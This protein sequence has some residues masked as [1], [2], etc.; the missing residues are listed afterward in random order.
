VAFLCLG[1]VAGGYFGGRPLLQQVEFA[2]AAA[3]VQATREQ[4]STVNDLSTVFRHVGKVVAPS[5]VQIRV[6]KELPQ[7]VG[8]GRRH[9]RIPGFGDLPIPQNDAPGQLNPGDNGPDQQQQPQEEVGTG[10]GVILEA[11]DGY[12]YILTNNHVAGGA[13]ELEVTLDDGR[14]IHSSD[15]KV[16]GADPKSDLAVVKIKADRLIAAKWGNSD[17]LEKGDWVMAF[18]S[19]FGYIG[20]MTHGIVS[21]LNRNGIIPNRNDYENYIQVDAPINPGNSGGPLVNIHG[22]VVGINV[23]IATVDGGFEGIGFAIPANQAKFVFSALKTNGKVTRGWLGVGIKDIADYEPGMAKSFNY[24]GTSGVLIEQ[25]APSSPAN[26]KL[27]EGDIVVGFNGT[28]IDNSSQLRNMVAATAPSTNIT[29]KI[30]RE[31]KEQEI[32]VPVGNQPDNVEL[33]MGRPGGTDNG[34]AAS[35]QPNTQNV[36]GM[37]LQTLDSD[38]ATKLSLTIKFGA[39]VTNVSRNSAAAKAQLRPGDVII[40]VGSTRVRTSQ[41]AADA[42]KKGSLKDG[43]RLYVVSSAGSRYELLQDD[44]ASQ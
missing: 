38:S 27:Q 31:G 17:E 8:S 12:G 22:E 43:V 40:R 2:R 13:S 3:D 5:V 16:L 10:S 11:T 14:K 4:L 23:A 19:P 26:G 7:S 34:A 21:A 42:I 36:A 30:F 35:D 6:T 37:D 39:L 44:K 29:L 28:A 20:S 32:E 24:S 25:I 15:C 9:M 18:G 41:E 1:A 33:A